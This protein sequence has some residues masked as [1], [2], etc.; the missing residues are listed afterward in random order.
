MSESPPTVVTVV[1]L[2]DIVRGVM[3]LRWF[4]LCGAVLGLVAG[5]V[6]G[7]VQTPIYRAS[8]VVMPVTERQPVPGAI[9]GL[10]GQ[11]GGRSMLQ[12]GGDTGKNEAV[13]VL[14]SRDLSLA[15]IRE[16]NLMPVL[17][18]SRW[19]PARGQW[20]P[21]EPDQIPTEWDAWE[22]FDKRVRRILEDEDRGLLT[23]Q[24]ELP[25]RE[26]A[27][28]VA[29]L[30]LTKANAEIRGRKL[31]E[32]DS[33][34]KLLE[35]ELGQ[36]SLVELRQAIAEVMQAQISQ[37]MMVRSQ[38]DYAFRVIDPAAVPDLDRPERPKKAF[39][40]VL[41]TVAGLLGGLGVGLFAGYRRSAA[42]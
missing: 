3:R 38:P 25:D 39:L 6:V 1:T 36:A 19:D 10:L 28:A 4:W 35:E 18:P 5:L 16:A 12:L 2:S 13:A 24:I 27:Q 8:V 31:A 20:K 7:F 9:G 26:Q 33:R 37:R 21:V 17:F 34:I 15:V 11:F 41:G 22:A 32:L 30:L 40:A 42:G 23:I 29:D 14:K